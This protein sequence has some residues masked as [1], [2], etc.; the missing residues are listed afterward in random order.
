MT[1]CHRADPDCQSGGG[2]QRDRVD[3]APQPQGWP[4]WLGAPTAR[5]RV[6]FSH[7]AASWII[8]SGAS[9]SSAT[10]A[11]KTGSKSTFPRALRSSSLLDGL[12]GD[13]FRLPPIRH[14][15]NAQPKNGTAGIPLEATLGKPPARPSAN[16]SK[17]CSGPADPSVPHPD[18][19]AARPGRTTCADEPLGGGRYPHLPVTRGRH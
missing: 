19:Q 11:R 4:E 14:S 17:I 12:Q 18:P 3:C 9:P 1:G 16:N 7:P 5:I 15:P 2:G 13:Q 8:S 6:T 10:T